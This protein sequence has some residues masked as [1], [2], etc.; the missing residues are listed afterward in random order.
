MAPGSTPHLK[1]SIFG[2]MTRAAAKVSRNYQTVCQ[3]ET[4]LFKCGPTVT[5]SFCTTATTTS[6]TIAPHSSSIIFRPIGGFIPSI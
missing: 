4:E 5:C 6:V 2:P 1:T 3:K